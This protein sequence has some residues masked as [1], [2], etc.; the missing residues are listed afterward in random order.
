[1]D[2]KQK[3]EEA[4][5]RAKMYQGMVVLPAESMIETI[6]PE[7]A[8]SEDEKVRKELIKVFSNREKYLIDQS[9]GDITVSEVLAWLEKQGK[10]EMLDKA[11]EWLENNLLNYWQQINTDSSKFIEDFRKAMEK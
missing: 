10:R 1:M 8:E 3:Y 11:C 2:Y 7:L 6:F 4:L 9:F 5:E